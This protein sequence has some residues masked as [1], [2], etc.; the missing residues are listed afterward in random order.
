MSVNDFSK[1][2]LLLIC[3]TMGL[4]GT[5][6]VVL[7]L[8]ETFSG[9]MA[10]ITVVSAGGQNE[11]RLAEL[12]VTHVLIPDITD[13]NP[14]A[15]RKIVAILNR[16]VRE[17]HINLIH[18]HHRMA[19]LYAHMLFPK[20]PKL[21]TAHNVFQDKRCLT[22]LA[23][24]NQIVVAC[25]PRVEEN[26]INYFGITN[27]R[28]RLVV[29]SVEPFHGPIISIP[30]IAAC[31]KGSLIIGFLGRLTEQKGCRYLIEAMGILAD[32]GVC[33]HCLI[34]GEGEY[35]DELHS[36]VKC[37]G[38]ENIVTF[39]GRRD[40]PQNFLSQVDVLAM[41]SLW[42]GLPLS[43]IEAFSV[44]VPVV[45]TTADGIMD[46]LEHGVNGLAVPTRDSEAMANG[47][48]ALS[49]DRNLLKR[50][51]DGAYKTYEER[52]GYS[53]WQQGYELIYKEVLS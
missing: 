48:E 34:A 45:G 39:L 35:E 3:R 27:A 46:A 9:K 19:A 12:G 11:D 1:I 21:S 17:K 16:T 18:S 8:C 41:P 43:L 52:F 24:A 13:R 14:S 40:D 47:L 7:Q 6:K 5:E 25:G 42:E 10:S 49:A 36:Q 31:P 37:L 44:G 15:C 2:N 32:R 38:L 29:N 53:T 28:V 50:L 26:L 33:T 20:I 22:R 51:S 23:Y 30:D 4:G